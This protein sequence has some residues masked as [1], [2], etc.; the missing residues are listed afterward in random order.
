MCGE[1]EV[2]DFERHV[3][4]EE[5]VAQFEISVKNGAMVNVTDTLADLEHVVTDLRLRQNLSALHDVKEGFHGAVLEDDVDVASVVGEEVAEADHVRMD[6]VFVKHDLTFH[7]VFGGAATGKDLAV[8]D[9]IS[10]TFVCQQFR[11]FIDLGEAAFAY[12]S[13]PSVCNLK[14]K[15]MTSFNAFFSSL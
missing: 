3:P 6:Q 13:T 5:H 12:Q 11:H 10:V 14:T 4:G 9:L 2:A 8:D 15:G 1:T 7:L